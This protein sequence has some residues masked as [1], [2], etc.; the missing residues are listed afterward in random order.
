MKIVRYIFILRDYWS[1]NANFKM[2]IVANIFLMLIRLPFSLIDKML[3]TIKPAQKSEDP[4]F[5]LGYYRSGTTHL[6]RLLSYNSNLYY[7]N[8]FKTYFPDAFLSM[9]FWFKPITQFLLNLFKVQ[10]PIHRVDFDWDL[11]GEEDIA[12]AFLPSKFSLNWLHAFPSQSKQCLE[13]AVLFESKEDKFLEQYDWYLNRLRYKSKEK[14]LLLKSPPNTGRIKTLLKKYP[15]AKFVF[16]QRDAF[17]TLASNRYMWDVVKEAQ[18]E[19]IEKT[20]RDKTIL[21]LEEQLLRIYNDQKSL[22]PKENLYE[23]S[24]EQLM[25]NPLVKIEQIFKQFQID[26]KAEDREGLETFIRCKHGK[27]QGNYSPSEY[28][29][30]ILEQYKRPKIL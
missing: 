30:S 11:P 9:E 4:V 25:D 21:K 20:A 24:F 28:D 6:Q 17:K 1:E 2:I 5:V 26:L 19:K 10:N 22:I 18:F 15:N 12:F 8:I 29:I 16:I 23:I 27:H 14:R 13:N 7:V 3:I